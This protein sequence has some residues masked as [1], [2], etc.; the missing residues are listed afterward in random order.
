LVI[1]QN[2]TDLLAVSVY[3]YT[4]DIHRQ[5]DFN[6]KSNNKKEQQIVRHVCI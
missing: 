4:L 1:A 6:N 3:G 5:K 2:R